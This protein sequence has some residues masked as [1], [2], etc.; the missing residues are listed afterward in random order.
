MGRPLPGEAEADHRFAGR[1]VGALY[2]NVMTPSMMSVMMSA[3]LRIAMVSM[4]MPFPSE[5]APPTYHLWFYTTPSGR[6]LA[7]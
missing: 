7:G 5:V 4:V 2:A 3:M 6:I 1:I